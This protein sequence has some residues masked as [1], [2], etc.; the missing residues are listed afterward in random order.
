M[1]PTGLQ[2]FV[3][4]ARPYS[5]TRRKLERWYV[6]HGPGRRL[7]ALTGD[8]A[9]AILQV[10]MHDVAPPRQRH[11]LE[12]LVKSLGDAYRTAGLP[13]PGWLGEVRGRVEGPPRDA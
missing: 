5:A 8:S 3:D 4:G 13:E 2:R 12:L 11:T 1:S 10:L 9:L 7:A 6:L